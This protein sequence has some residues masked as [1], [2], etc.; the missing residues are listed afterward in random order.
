MNLS[1][2][3]CSHNPRE[4]YLRRVLD[5]LKAQTLSTEQ[6]ELLLIDNASKEPLA[7]SWDLSWHPH[8]RHIRE[9]ELGLTPA[10]LCGIKE[11]VGELLVF[12]DDDN[13]LDADYLEQASRVFSLQPMAGA[14]GAGEV[15]G[16]FESEVPSEIVPHLGNIAV[17]RNDHDA[18]SNA[19]RDNHALPCGAGLCLARK[20]AHH[21][22]ITIGTR[23]ILGRQG[24]NTM[25]CED[26]D[27]A[28]TACDLGLLAGRLTVLKMDH[29]I[30]QSRITTQYFEK[31]IQSLV[32][33][34]MLLQV[35]RGHPVP[36]NRSL[37]RQFL[38]YLR[39]LRKPSFEKR[40]ARSMQRGINEARRMAK[41]LDTEQAS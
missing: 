35:M 30:P 23:R 28:L 6:W 40:I 17:F 33:S 7:K 29:L 38:D 3:I 39:Y 2:V 21:Y 5:A 41:E 10:R 27:M 37:P 32:C 18:W 4:D 24:T 25:S 11:S 36:P 14:F 15:R 12:V 19:R 34:A 1:V 8:A 13:V 31:L 16:I 9:D 22:S 20:A 26:S